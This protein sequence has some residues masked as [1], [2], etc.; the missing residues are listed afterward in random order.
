MRTS[1]SKLASWP[2]KSVD[3]E[4]AT[5]KMVCFCSTFLKLSPADCRETSTGADG[6]AFFFSTWRTQSRR[7]YARTVMA[8]SSN[9]T[10]ADQRAYLA[11]SLRNIHLVKQSSGRVYSGGQKP[12]SWRIPH[13]PEYRGEYR[14]SLRPRYRDLYFSPD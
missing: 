1:S 7:T 3:F 5:S 11:A 6:G 8:A 13:W 9:A 2:L 10:I 14:C 12:L 4:A